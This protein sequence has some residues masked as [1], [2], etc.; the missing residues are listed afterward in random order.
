M[1]F[2]FALLPMRSSLSVVTN[3]TIMNPLVRLTS[4]TDQTSEH[5]LPAFD[6]GYSVLELLEPRLSKVMIE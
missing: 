3:Y 2:L 5:L 6:F 4:L 1:T